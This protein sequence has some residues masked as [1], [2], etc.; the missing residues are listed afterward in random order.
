MNLSMNKSVLL[1]KTEGTYNVDAAPTGALNAILAINLT[2]TPLEQESQQ[3]NL[4]RPYMGNDE[5]IPVGTKVSISFE[6]EASGAGAAGDVPAYGILLTSSGMEEEITV[7]TDVRYKPISSA[8]KS[9]TMIYN[10]DGVSHK[11]TGAR[12]SV[13]LT[14]PAKGVPRYK[15]TFVGLYA[16]VVDAN[17]VGVDYSAFIKPLAVNKRNTPTSTLF[18]QAIVTQSLSLDVGMTVAYRNL[19]GYEGVD[20]TDRASRGKILFQYTK[21]ATYN[22][23]A[24]IKAGN[25]G[26]LSFVHG[27]TAGNIVEIAASNVQIIN[28]SIS[29]SDGTAMLGLDLN[30]NPTEAGNDEFEIIVR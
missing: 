2:V 13:E 25:S 18:G 5:Q 29:D 7:D 14:F 27:L 21:V 1:A 16:D 28:P 20:L 22:W 17:V 12:G 23:F 30:Y 26:A 10:L 19:V 4:V 11:C 8:F 6:V 24:A 9:L 3:R 15:F